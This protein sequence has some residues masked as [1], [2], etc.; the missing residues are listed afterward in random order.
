M[1]H[2]RR[3][4]AVR[5]L[6]VYAFDPAA[7]AELDTAVINASVIELPW[8]ARWEDPLELGPTNEYLEVIDLDPGSGLFYAPVD[9]DDPF[10]LAQDGLAP[11]E[12]D[13][14]FHQ[15]MA[16]AVAMKTI[17]IFE[18]ALGRVVL[19]A[20]PLDTSR[21]IGYRKY[22]KRLRIYPHA[23]RQKN[24]YY[25]PDKSALLFGYFR[26]ENAE[27]TPSRWVFTCLSHDIVAHET[28]HA[29]LHGLHQRTIE[30]S[31]PDSLA[32]HEAFADIVA[33]CQHFTMTDAIEQQIA[34][35]GGT[36]RSSELLIGLAQQFGVATGKHGPL[37]YALD[38]VDDE[39]AKGGKGPARIERAS[40]P[41]NRGTFLVAAVFDALVTMFGRRT[42]DLFR[43]AR[44]KPG[45]TEIPVELVRRLA[46]EASKTADHVLRM[47]VRGLDYL[48]PVD[49]TFG[50]YLR[51]II[52]ADADLAPHDPLHYRVAF[53]ESFRKHGI[54]LL[55]CISYA[56][57]SLMW[58]EPDV[59][60]FPLLLERDRTSI[61]GLFGDLLKDIQLARSQSFDVR[62]LREEAMR[63]VE[64]N[65]EAVHKW[66]MTP[67]E[68]SPDKPRLDREREWEKLLG[69]QL[70][71]LK[72]LASVFLSKSATF[73]GHPSVEVSAARIAR[74]K[75][76]DGRELTQLI[77]HVIQRRRGYFDKREQAAAD[78][79]DFSETGSFN[80]K[81][82]RWNDPDFIFR[83]GSTL[84]IDLRDGRLRRL[85]RKRITD[86]VRLDKQRKFYAGDSLSLALGD[87]HAIAEPFAMVCRRQ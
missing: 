42:Q 30:A 5:R 33:L 19:W 82:P 28:T 57:E 68:D 66:L 23:M 4:P 39:S 62:N 79:G 52:S 40:E 86:D 85:V 24:A 21:P 65:Q 2:Q 53:C 54:P 55:D 77:I 6:R 26:D 81:S 18:R 60:E 8:E 59:F 27:P 41:H 80:H 17:R 87:G 25:S 13:P 83:G 38:P 45:S 61:G 32:F 43:L 10:L 58:E 78:T 15:Q 37:R 67:A 84:I 56:P 34:A 7:S 22:C 71:D 50:E 73:Q 9:L 72:T 20:S 47:C 69:V 70:L 12:S 11:V 14:Q 64:K 75:G 16:F 31:N 48:P 3:F 76:P 35:R 74:R 63:V 51:A 44:N 1:T 36:L 29:I 49:I 46:Q